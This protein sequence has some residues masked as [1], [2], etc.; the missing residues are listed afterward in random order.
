METTVKRW[1]PSWDNTRILLFLGFGGLLLLMAVAAVDAI[2]ILTAIQ[3]RNDTIRREFLSKN[4]LLNQIRS[5]LY[6]S[7]TYVRDYLLEPEPDKA[8]GH[9]A[10]LENTRSD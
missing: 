7:G 9:R 2:Q 1:N 4:Q 5:D 3:D 6:I 10:S 8:F